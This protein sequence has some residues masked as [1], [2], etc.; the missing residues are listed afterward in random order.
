MVF[1]DFLII[2]TFAHKN[3]NAEKQTRFIPFLAKQKI[4]KKHGYKH[5]LQYYQEKEEKEI[6]YLVA[7]TYDCWINGQIFQQTLV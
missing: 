7:A 6:C 4:E 5:H 3:I 1:L 2:R